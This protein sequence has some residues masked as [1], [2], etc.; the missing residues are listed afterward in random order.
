MKK[1]IN[2]LPLMALVLGFGLMSFRGTTETPNYGFD[3]ISQEWVSLDGLTEVPGAPDNG[4]YRCLPPEE[5]EIC[6][7]YF[8]P[9]DTEFTNPID[10]ELGVFDYV[11]P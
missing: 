1:L 11:A 6:K 4:E 10:E 8:A 9:E 5:S 2:L 7:A 3:P